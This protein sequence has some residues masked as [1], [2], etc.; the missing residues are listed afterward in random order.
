MHEKYLGDSY[1]LV[2]RSFVRVCARLIQTALSLDNT[3]AIIFDLE[4]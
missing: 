2:K 1:D 3:V 4:E